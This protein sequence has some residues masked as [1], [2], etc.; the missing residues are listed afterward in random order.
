MSEIYRRIVDHKKFAEKCKD[1][2]ESTGRKIM[3]TEHMFVDDL[4]SIYHDSMESTLTHLSEIFDIA[5]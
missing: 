2:K 1:F 3:L 5:G 4:Q